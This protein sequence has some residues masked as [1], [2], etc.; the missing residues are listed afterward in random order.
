M[1]LF[2]TIPTSADSVYVQ[3]S[4][5]RPSNLCRL[6]LTAIIHN[7]CVLLKLL[8]S[9]SLDLNGLNMTTLQSNL[10]QNVCDVYEEISQH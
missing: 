10:S 1:E 4:N 9:G 6:S 8:M 7:A 5:V 2:R 3:S